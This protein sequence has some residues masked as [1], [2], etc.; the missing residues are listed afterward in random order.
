M[1]K[2]VYTGQEVPHIFATGPDA[3]ARNSNKTLFC[4]NGV[5]YSYRY[6]APIAA[7]RDGKILVNSDTYSV[8]TSKHQ[9][10][11]RYAVRHLESVTLP[12]LAAILGSNGNAKE[13]A[14]YIAARSKEIDALREKAGRARSEWSK[15]SLAAQIASLEA[16]CAYVWKEIAKKKTPWQNAI[17]FDQKARKE[18]AKARYIYAR[19]Q[20][21]SGLENAARILEGSQARIDRESPNAGRGD[22]FYILENAQRDIRRLDVMGA[23]KG[24]DLGSTATFTDAARLMGKT[25]AKDCTRLALEIHAFAN[26]MQPRIDRARAEFD[27]AQR[28]ENA[29]KIAAW[30]AGENVRYPSNL[31]VA[32]RVIGGDTVET[33]KG[34]RVPLDAALRLVELAKAC[35]KSGK[36][37]DLRGQT[38]GAYRTTGIDADGALTVGCH[39]IPWQSIADAVARFD[40]VAA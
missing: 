36:A 22:Y 5:L 19:K 27:A 32:C 13:I 2:T 10:W 28:L 14:K 17:A 1:A 26:A 16:A 8:T 33:S 37:M 23:A 30:L 20:L 18:D 11:A 39:F 4:E 21:D 15:S 31:P 35:R 9:S 40:G 24:L 34:A 3:V 7:W 38:I 25:W 6:S 12:S 29:E